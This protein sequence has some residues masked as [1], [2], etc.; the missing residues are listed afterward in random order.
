M[1]G[2]FL[3]DFNLNCSKYKD[4]N[5]NRRMYYTKNIYLKWAMN[6]LLR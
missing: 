3:G 1:I 4:Q 2:D 5:S 6:S